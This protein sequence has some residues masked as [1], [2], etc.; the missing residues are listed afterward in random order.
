[1]NMTLTTKMTMTP[2]RRRVTL[3]KTPRRITLAESTSSLQIFFVRLFL[4][5]A[6]FVHCVDSIPY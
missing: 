4:E 6:R 1:M 5:R 3:T 2:R